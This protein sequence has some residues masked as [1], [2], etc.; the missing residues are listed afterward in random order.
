MESKINKKVEV[1]LEKYR[2]SIR[3]KVINLGLET[4]IQAELL[5]TIYSFN[6]LQLEKED[7]MKRKRIVSQVP[8]SDRCMAK[9]ANGEQC[10]RKKKCSCNFCG[11]HD[12]FQPH[13]IVENNDS[14]ISLKKCS[15]TIMDI[16]GI[17]YYVDD[18]GNV[19]D[20]ADILKNNN[21]P[22]VIG[23]ICTLNGR[24]EFITN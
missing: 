16:N 11:T 24:S 10:T 15:I 9:K 20:T 7:F 1:Y 18:A 19:Y 4:S 13:G 5:E 2:E 17:N 8:V 3:D 12:K 23:K 6:T 21:S 14:V 22:K